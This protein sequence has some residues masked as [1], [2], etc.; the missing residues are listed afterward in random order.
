MASKGL[1]FTQFDGGIA[2]ADKVGIKYSFANEQALDFRKNPSQLTPLG[3]PRRE[4]A[5]VAK[6][7]ILNEIMVPDGSIYAFGNGGFIYRRSTTGVWSVIGNM[8]AG[9]G[10]VDYR[11]DSDSLYFTARRNVGLF[12]PVSGTPMLTAKKYSDS[13][14]TLD[15]SATTGFNVAAYQS[16]GT[17]SSAIGT[18]IIENQDNLRYFQSDIEPLDKISVYVLA[19][20]TGDWTLTLHDG[21]NNV[22]GTSTVTN[23][24]LNNNAFN[25]FAFT[26]AP[27]S[28]VRIYIAPNARTYH[29]HV[30]STVA[31]GS[32]S[33]TNKND[34]SSCDLEV[35]ADRLVVTNNGLHPMGRFLQ[36]E[37]IGNGNYLSAW[38][39]I[40]D[41]PTNAEW[42]RHRLV[43]PMEYEVCGLAFTNEFVVVAAQQTSTNANAVPQQGIIFFWDGISST[44]N[45]DLPITEG[46]PM[47]LH[48]YQNVV[49][50][51]ADGA[52]WALTSPTT[53]PTKLRT[54]PGS[55]TVFSGAPAPITVYP[56]AATVRRG[57]QLM[58]Y[59]SVTTNTNINFGVYSWGAVDKN[60]PQSF[61]YNYV[62]STGSKLYSASNNLQIGMVK[63]F[64]DT[65]HVSWRDDL[66]GGYGIDVVDNTSTPAYSTFW[67]SLIFD[68]GWPGKQKTGLYMQLYYDL[69]N[70]TGV[71]L[72][73]RYNINR[74]GW[75]YGETYTINNLWLGRHRICEFA[76]DE[77]DSGGNGG[78]FYEIQIGF[79]LTCDST[80]TT[81]PVVYMAMLAFDDNTGE[82]IK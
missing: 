28:Q 42:Q 27:N 10:G 44:Y 34:M 60:F 66:N 26:S 20:G 57:I 47:G 82:G 67:E 2:T 39:P 5:G 52:W 25:D 80:V 77:T 7:L 23:A 1:V 64:G 31:D 16:G 59:P 8:P 49:Y 17:Q 36:Y 40:S 76:I 81:P 51:Y 48:T 79:D 45:Y 61:G 13:Y 75:V 62:I 50:Y 12:A 30:T 73:P 46:S 18:A 54:M 55:D 24:N 70:Q 19:K 15:N 4:D 21:D 33:S 35:W 63:N 32:I 72:T 65:L 58:A 56:Y 38:E 14:S 78:R 69:M 6:D 71:T 68:N 3:Q 29:I 53:E 37:V 11:K 22:L 43:F 41:P 74:S 9:T